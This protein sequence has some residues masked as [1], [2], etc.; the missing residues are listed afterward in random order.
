MDP[1][2]SISLWWVAFAVTHLVGS[3]LS[4]R[5]VLIDRLGER[6]FQG[7]YS[8]VALAT[9]L[10]LMLVWWGHRHEGA[11]LF[12][13]RDVAAVRGL[14]IGLSLLGFVLIFY[15]MLQPSPLSIAAQGEPRAHGATR[16]TRH[17][18][19]MGMLLWALGHLLVN[20]WLTDVA[21]YGG[22][23]AFTV[24][25][26]MHQDARRRESDGERVAGLYAETS[27]LPFVAIV[28]GRGRL[29]LGELS[30]LPAALGLGVGW[31]L[32][33]FHPQLFSLN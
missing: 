29:A 1:A 5:R 16:I 25:G 9:F 6:G 26:S 14:A 19:F 10:P 20:G 31:A 18:L 13:L 27:L 22:F 15:G 11:M 28:Q 23:A 7:V 21:F 32:Y 24:I 8:V 4:V 12:F 17:P 30:L 33:W 2:A 3:S